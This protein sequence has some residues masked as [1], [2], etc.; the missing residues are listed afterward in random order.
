MHFSTATWSLLSFSNV[1]HI[2]VFKALFHLSTEISVT[3]HFLAGGGSKA[4]IQPRLLHAGE[5]GG[6]GDCECGHDQ[7]VS[8]QV[9]NCMDMNKIDWKLSDDRQ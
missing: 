1:S 3:L 7:S 8:A 6:C 5:I 4:T 2:D 9:R